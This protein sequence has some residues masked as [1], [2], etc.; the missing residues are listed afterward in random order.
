MSKK[1]LHL[2]LG[3]HRVCCS[4]LRVRLLSHKRVWAPKAFPKVL[5]APL[6]LLYSTWRLGFSIPPPTFL[7]SARREF[8]EKIPKMGANS[9]FVWGMRKGLS[10]HY[11]PHSAFSNFLQNL[12]RFLHACK[13][14]SISSSH[15]MNSWDCA[16]RY[17]A[18]SGSTPLEG[19]IFH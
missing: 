17:R 13:V 9:P 6:L 10:S 11:S 8:T 7:V 14:P 18:V 15:A 1:D 19:S 5:A 12:T 2:C 4:S 3:G 16:I